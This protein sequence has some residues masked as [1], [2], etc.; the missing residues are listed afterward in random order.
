MSF[1]KPISVAAALLL[2]S[3]VACHVPA[4]DSAGPVTKPATFKI[5]W[6]LSAGSDQWPADKRKAITDAMNAAV[7]FYNAHGEF[8][9]QVTVSYNPGTPTADAN[10]NGHIRFGGSISRR[11][12]LHEIA[13]TLGVGQHPNWDKLLQNGKWTGPK[14]VALLREFDG[15]TADLKGDRQHFWPYGLNFDNESDPTKDLRHVKMVA[16]LRED[17]GIINGK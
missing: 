7:A 12:A 5:S 4:K 14:A 9:K 6:K 11:V 8:D 13:H 16:A 15:P 3:A 17:M 2:S 10:W 1:R